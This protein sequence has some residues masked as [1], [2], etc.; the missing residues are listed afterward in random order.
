MSIDLSKSIMDVI[1]Y[2]TS[3]R[4]YDNK[5]LSEE[6]KD[7]L[8]KHIDT[9]NNGPFNEKVRFKIIDKADKSNEDVKLGTYGVIKGARA[10]IVASI[11]KNDEALEQL[12]YTLEDIVLY[13]TSLGIGTVWLGGTFN[14]GEFAKAIDIKA[15]EIVP[16]VLP[17]GISAE[18]KSLTE[19]M[20]RFVTRAKNRKRFSNM[21]FSENFTKQLDE[22]KAGEYG[23]ALEMVRLA[24]SASNKQPWRIIVDDE[25]YHFFLSH[26]KGYRSMGFD[27]QKIDIGIAMYH[28]AASAKELNLKGHWSKK[29]KHIKK[30]PS[31]T[32]FIMSWIKEIPSQK[33]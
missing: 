14:K 30:A 20:M 32:E 15:N 22:S 4:T 8:Q 3:I 25:G 12:G 28:F 29:F 11:K 26:T 21:F 9:V 19:K 23:K 5:P 24:P 27:M 1:K 7:K 16:I 2:R 17:I 13:A 31:E 33:F 6:L 10:F 18:K